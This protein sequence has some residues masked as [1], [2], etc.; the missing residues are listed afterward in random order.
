MTATT[1]VER[2]AEFL[3]AAHFRRVPTPLE[4]AGLQIDVPSVFIGPESSPDLVLVGDTL[5]QIKSK[6]RKQPKQKA[7]ADQQKPRI[8]PPASRSP[9]GSG[10]PVSSSRSSSRQFKN[11]FRTFLQVTP[12]LP[13]HTL[14]RPEQSN[15]SGSG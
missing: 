12:T 15:R 13:W 14:G 3:G 5:P 7:R 10:M 11:S 2:V 1:P 6:K 4:I 8:L 9:R